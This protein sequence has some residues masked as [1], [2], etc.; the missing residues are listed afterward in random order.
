[1]CAAL[2]VAPNFGLEKGS[3][4]GAESNHRRSAS[5]PADYLPAPPTVKPKSS[6][7]M[8]T[9]CSSSQRSANSKSP[10]S[11]I[12]IA[13]YNKALTAA[14]SPIRTN[15]LSHGRDRNWKRCRARATLRNARMSASINQMAS[16]P[17]AMRQTTGAD[18]CIAD[19]AMGNIEKK[20]TVILQV[21]KNAS[22]RRSSA[23]HGPA[24]RTPNAATTPEKP[25]MATPI[26]ANA[27]K[28]DRKSTRMN[29]S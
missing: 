15:H 25:A 11:A 14:A 9:D 10:A 8:M 18:M 12:Q 28:E 22:R 4:P 3:W 16:N 21:T 1:M 29:S 6:V 13:L 27:M 26:S 20:T 2:Y 7:N 17:L 5:A 24:A 23:V 19:M